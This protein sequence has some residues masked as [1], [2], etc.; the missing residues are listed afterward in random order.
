MLEKV[1][2]D[3]EAKGNELFSFSKDRYMTFALRE[4]RL[5]EGAEWQNVRVKYYRQATEPGNTTSH[6]CFISHPCKLTWM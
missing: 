2:A 4:D 3:K 1:K 6:L 5:P